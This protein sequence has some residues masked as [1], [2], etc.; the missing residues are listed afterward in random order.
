LH[1]HHRDNGPPHTSSNTNRVPHEH[2]G[3]SAG[4][5]L[6]SQ[7][8]RSSGRARE[9]TASSRCDRSR[10]F[11]TARSGAHRNRGSRRPPGDHN[12]INQNVDDLRARRKG[13]KLGI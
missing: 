2:R 6:P 1:V 10:Q 5:G 9:P 11:R 4:R 8:S 7:L 12:L 13:A 3:V